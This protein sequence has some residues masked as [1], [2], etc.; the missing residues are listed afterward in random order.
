M[1]L[2]DHFT[3][4][5]LVATGSLP[6]YDDRFIERK[7]SRLKNAFEL[8]HLILQDDF[9]QPM[10]EQIHFESQGSIT[11]IP[12]LGRH[13]IIFGK[14][15]DAEDKLRKLKIFYKEALPHEGWRK[16]RTVDLSYEGQV[17]CKKR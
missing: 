13:K 1:P 17:V 16:Y 9:L 6:N 5:V 3:A 12:K 4:K 15:E 7:R 10:I 14:Y 8:T 2:S 11:L